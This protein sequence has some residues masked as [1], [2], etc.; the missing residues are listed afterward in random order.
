MINNKPGIYNGFGVY[1]IGGGVDPFDNIYLYPVKDGD[2][3]I[4]GENYP[5]KKINNRYWILKNLY[6]EVPGASK[7][8]SGNPSSASYWD[9]YGDNDLK[10][11]FGFQYNGYCVQ[12][13]NSNLPAGWRVPNDDDFNDLITGFD[14]N[15]L[16]SLKCWG[17]NTNAV[18]PTNKSFFN[19]LPAGQRADGVNNSL[20]AGAYYW[21]TSE[22]AGGTGRL[23]NMRLRDET[24]EVTFGYNA[25]SR[26]RSIIICKDL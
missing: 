10:Y 14:A 23:N 8:P 4:D 21:S 5:Y 17:L 20:M 25:K 7:N 1:K 13:I 12:I 11:I 2:I 16:K 9:C 3:T 26:S 22:E 24:N 15:D 19:A 18:K 6:M